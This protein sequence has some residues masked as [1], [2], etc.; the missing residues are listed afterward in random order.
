MRR[1]L[2]LLAIAGCGFKH[3]ALDPIVADDASP[4]DDAAIDA[5]ADAM[6][7]ARVVVIIPYCNTQDP[8]LVACYQ[9]E[10]NTN[11][12]S[13]HN[14][15]ASMTN[16]TFS[17]GK[18]G[19]A[20]NSAANSAT[21][22]ADSTMWNLNALTIEAWINPSALPG[23]GLRMGIVDVEGQ[24]GFFLHETGRL[25]CTIIN[26]ITMQVDASV[27]ANTWSHVAC[28]YDGTTTTIYKD[29]AV[30]FTGTGGGT[31]AT[32]GVTGMSIGANNPPGSGS[33]FIGLIDEV[34]MM[35]RARTGPEICA[36]AECATTQ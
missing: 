4:P 22:V 11:D 33:R 15:N 16:V 25:Q 21:D 27:A 24:Y 26:G 14:L 32:N 9:F 20:L 17:N 28:T 19:M 35:S 18:V 5:A 30:V 29:G 7:D 10:N 3:G 13:G 12:S 1:A 2:L 31:V 34:R 6:I 23:T 36:D 8:N